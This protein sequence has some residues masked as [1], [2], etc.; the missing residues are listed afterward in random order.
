MIPKALFATATSPV[1]LTVGGHKFRMVPVRGG[2]FMMGDEVA[3]SE[4]VTSSHP[5][6]TH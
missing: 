4:G 1:P 5:L 6:T 2:T 3:Q